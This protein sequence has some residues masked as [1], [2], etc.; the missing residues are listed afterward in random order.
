MVV[1]SRWYRA[2]PGL[3]LRQ[4]WNN[5]QLRRELAGSAGEETMVNALRR[6]GAAPKILPQL[7]YARIN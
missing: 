7:P 3:S 5:E 2:Y 1:H 4:V 6:L